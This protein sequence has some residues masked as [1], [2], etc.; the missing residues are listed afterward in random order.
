MLFRSAS[1]NTILL[2]D[3]YNG[4]KSVV[5]PA[6]TYGYD[7]IVRM[8]REQL[9]SGWY[10][11][12]L[13]GWCTMGFVYP[14]TT[15]P[16]T[17]DDFTVTWTSAGNVQAILE[18]PTMGTPPWNFADDG[19]YRTA[20]AD[21]QLEVCAITHLRRDRGHMRP[22]VNSTRAWL[23]MGVLSG[24]AN[25]NGLEVEVRDPGANGNLYT[26]RLVND[27]E[28]IQQSGKD[29]TI[30]FEAGV[31]TIA[32]LETLINTCYAIRVKTSIGGATLVAGG[33][34]SPDNFANGVTGP[35]AFLSRGYRMTNATR[36]MTYIALLPEPLATQAKAD[37]VAEY[38]RQYGPAGYKA[39]VEFY[40]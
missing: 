3:S 7:E 39:Q 14:G 9:P 26:L 24:D 10:I 32:A 15:T 36:P 37:A 2:N 6:G 5:I 8:V 28:Y 31:T 13:N 17:P 4:D 40:P 19:P 18:M 11:R 12:A 34:E 29:I 35:T 30:C 16:S 23:D 33:D 21:K 25:L 38:L 22:T 1:T 20:V 27:A